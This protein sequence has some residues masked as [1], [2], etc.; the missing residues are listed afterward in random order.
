MKL[1]TTAP[2]VAL[3][4]LLALAGCAST[5]GSGSHP[6]PGMNH[7]TPTATSPPAA[8]DANDADVM[9]AQTMIP[10]HQQ[11]IDMADMLLAKDG[12]DARVT[13]LA[14]QIKTAQQPE[15]AQ[16]T[17]WLSDWG[18]DPAMDTMGGMGDG[19]MTDAD[20]TA[21]DQ[22]TGVDASRLFLQQM[23]THHQG[24]IDMAHQEVDNGR[25]DDA[26][27]MARTIIDTQTA[28]IATMQEILD[29]L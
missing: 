16:L 10:H 5:T 3:A 14:Q 23:T 29:T 12:I 28:E 18:A 9:F 27:G 11:A 24:A 20:M 17:T 2:I 21:L 22:A 4:A 6:M 26:I 25:N 13:E 8:G 1:R 19:M 15:I 7:D